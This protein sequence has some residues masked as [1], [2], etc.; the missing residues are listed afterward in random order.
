MES[1]YLCLL[2]LI[3]FVVYIFYKNQ[4]KPKNEENK[5]LDNLYLKLSNI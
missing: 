1:K 2:L 4:N 5:F 3:I